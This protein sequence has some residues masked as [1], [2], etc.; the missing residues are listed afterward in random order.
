MKRMKL[1]NDESASGSSGSHRVIRVDRAGSSLSLNDQRTKG[2][3]SIIQ[4]ISAS[5]LGSNCI[6]G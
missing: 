6:D 4:P 5:I 2:R 3:I 1:E